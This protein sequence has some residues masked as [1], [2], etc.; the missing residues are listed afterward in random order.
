MKITEKQQNDEIGNVDEGNK[1]PTMSKH[2]LDT[3]RR[4]V[5]YDGRT[6]IDAVIDAVI[7]KDEGKSAAFRHRNN[8]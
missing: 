6:V 3:Q 1:V 4:P 7:D 2:G 8:F 5:W